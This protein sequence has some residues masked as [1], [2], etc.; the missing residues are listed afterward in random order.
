MLN[1][2]SELLKIDTPILIGFQWDY[3][4][5]FGTGT[6]AAPTYL[7]LDLYDIFFAIAPSATST[8]SVVPTITKFAN[9]LAT[10]RFTAAQTAAMSAGEWIGHSFL[11]LKSS[12]SVSFLAKLEICVINP[13]PTP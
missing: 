2:C 7:D 3:S 9:G 11:Q 12:D 5:Q 10:Y 1:N 4:L 6:R 13:V 8:L